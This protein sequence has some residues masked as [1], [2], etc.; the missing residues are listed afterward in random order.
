M[1]FKCDYCSEPQP[2]G[3]KPNKVVVET[4]NVTYRTKDGQTPSGTE[5]VK[6]VDLCT[7]CVTA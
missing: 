2:N 7:G 6:E 3:I 4:R 1:S 5:I